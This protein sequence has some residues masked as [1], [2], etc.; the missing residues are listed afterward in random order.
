[1]M[2]EAWNKIKRKCIKL[3]LQPI[4][5]LCFHQVSE[6]YNPLMMWDCDW[7]Q[8]DQFKRN[9]LHLR[10]RGVTFISLP[11]AHD[12]LKHDWF[13]CKKYAVLTADD[14]YKSLHTILPWLEEQ[15]I[16]ITLFVNTRYLDGKSWSAINE[17]QARRAKPDAD[18]A[19]EVCPN[20]YLSKEELRQVAEMPN[21]T[22]GMHGHEHL[23]AC[24]QTRE[25]FEQNVRLCWEELKEYAHTIP[26]FAYTWGRHTLETDDILRTKKITPVI[27]R[28][29]MNYNNTNFI[30]RIAIDGKDESSL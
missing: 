26:Y 4:R 19:K 23:D 12:R 5:V 27:I 9:I 29:G 18:M 1:M 17:E 21:V 24:L 6:E 16:P 7:T 8:T 20:L 30:D 14:G 15:Q 13:R 11:E 22:I 3:R 28:G 2:F 25:K 10:A